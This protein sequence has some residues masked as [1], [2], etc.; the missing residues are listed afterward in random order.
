MTHRICFAVVAGWILLLQP[1][2]ADDGVP[3]LGVRWTIS[4]D[5]AGQLVSHEDLVA[6]TLDEPVGDPAGGDDRL[7]EDL[8]ESLDFFPGG[9]EPFSGGAAMLVPNSLGDSF[10]TGGQIVGFD[11]TV[12]VADIPG[13]RR[14]KIAENHNVMPQDRVYFM[15]QGFHNAGTVDS[16]F[17]SFIGTF[18]YG[19]DRYTLGWE[20]KLLGGIASVDLRLPFRTPVNLDLGGFFAGNGSSYLDNVAATFKVLLAQTDA[21]ALSAGTSLTLPTA[22]D[23]TGFVNS[24]DFVLQNE[25]VHLSPFLGMSQ[26]VTERFFWQ[27]FAQ[28]DIDTNGNRLTSEDFFPTVP[29]HMLQDQTLLYLDASAGYWLHRDPCAPWLTG[30][31]A[32]LELHYTGTLDDADIVSAQG[33]GDA[34]VVGNTANRVDVLNLTAGLHAEFGRKLDARTA[35]VVPLRDGTDRMFDFE[36][37]AQVNY[38]F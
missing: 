36:L 26:V 29:P 32:M 27:G 17:S 34:V 8:G 28:L 33:F 18:D 6:E 25:A 23:V 12:V 3:A 37:V 30:L 21:T 16:D 7:L 24:S 11:G 38:K 9:E 4:D 5:D 13:S 1:L 19:V 35:A 10:F 14:A 31:A 2:A 20:K 15:Y 22:A